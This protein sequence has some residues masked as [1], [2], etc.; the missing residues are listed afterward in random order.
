MAKKFHTYT[1]VAY[2]SVLP[3]APGTAPSVEDARDAF[4]IELAAFHLS[5]KKNLMVCEA[6]TRQVEEYK[7]EKER[8]GTRSTPPQSLC[9]C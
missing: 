6:E 1:S 5:L 2:D 9:Q 7:R 3:L 4:L 8:I